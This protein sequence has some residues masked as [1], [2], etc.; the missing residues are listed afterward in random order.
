M[1]DHL[2]T[3]TLSQRAFESTRRRVAALSAA[4]LDRESVC[5]GWDVRAI[6][7]HLVGG[8]IRFA[9]ALR[10]E[11]A[12]WPTRDDE[13]ITDALRQFDETAAIMQDAVAGIAD[14][15]RPTLL[16]AGE[17]P[18]FFAVGVHGADMLVHGW[19]IA[20]STDQDPTLDPSLCAAALW[21]LEQYP[22]SFW[23]PGQFFATKGSTTSDDPQTRLLTLAGRIS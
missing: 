6:L 19:D 2:D 17:P 9:Q 1:A 22:S 18:A 15:N 21:V 12:D 4:D 14:P 5:E 3:T 10:G 7:A 13:V 8:N 20:M 23:G 11:P 16:Q